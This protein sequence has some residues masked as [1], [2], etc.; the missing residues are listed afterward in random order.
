MKIPGVGK[1]C[2]KRWNTA[3]VCSEMKKEMKEIKTNIGNGEEEPLGVSWS[4][5]AFCGSL[6]LVSPDSGGW[7]LFDNAFLHWRAQVGTSEIDKV[8]V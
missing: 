1:H 4:A 2:T 5:A 6:F 3:W 7:V 8:S